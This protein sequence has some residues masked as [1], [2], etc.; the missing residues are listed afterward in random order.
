LRVGFVKHFLFCSCL[1]GDGCFRECV[2]PP[3]TSG[4]TLRSIFWPIIESV[5]LESPSFSFPDHRKH[6]SALRFLPSSR[7]LFF[8]RP[9]GDAPFPFLSSVLINGLR[10]GGRTRRLSLTSRE[11]R[12]LSPPPFLLRFT[13]P[14]FWFALSP[15]PFGRVNF[16]LNLWSRPCSNNSSPLAPPSRPISVPYLFPLTPFPFFFVGGRVKSLFFSPMP[17]CPFLGPSTRLR[18]SWSYVPFVPSYKDSRVPPFS[19]FL[20]YESPLRCPSPLALLPL[21]LPAPSCWAGV[22]TP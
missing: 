6:P 2:P 4:S 15:H 17:L 7:I 3:L 19:V 11:A 20:S 8:S 5:F 21:A 12:V 1:G 9:L 13:V 18:D 14:T 10:Y 22:L 16:S